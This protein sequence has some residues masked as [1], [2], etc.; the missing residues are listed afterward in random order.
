MS[1]EEQDLPGLSEVMNKRFSRREVLLNAAL[2]A[3]A[4]TSLASL[5]AACGGGRR[6]HDGAVRQ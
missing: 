6:D 2:V 5:L 1:Q 3:G 4:G